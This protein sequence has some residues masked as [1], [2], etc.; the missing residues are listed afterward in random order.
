MKWYIFL[1]IFFILAFLSCDDNELLIEFVLIDGSTGQVDLRTNKAILDWT[2]EYEVDGCGFH[3]FINDHKYK[4]ENESDVDDSF[5]TT[6]D[7]KVTIEYILLDY[8]ISS[9]CGDLPNSVLT[10]AIRIYSIKI[11]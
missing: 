10:D 4:A 1:C 5:K 2:G 7:S 8:Q 6:N 9:A 3:I 11:E